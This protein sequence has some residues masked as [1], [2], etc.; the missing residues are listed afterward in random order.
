MHGIDRKMDEDERLE[1][2]GKVWEPFRGSETLGD[3]SKN[4][5]D[6]DVLTVASVKFNVHP[7]STADHPAFAGCGGVGA[8]ATGCCCIVH[9]S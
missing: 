7:L 2:G 9:K 5:G 8:H 1:K 6:W 4:F 3:G